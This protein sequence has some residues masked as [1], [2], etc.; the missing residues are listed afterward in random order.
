MRQIL[1]IGAE[2][3]SGPFF[4]PDEATI[5]VHYLHQ[6]GASEGSSAPEAI[7]GDIEHY[8]SRGSG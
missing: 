2:I 3:F 4:G 1:G 7:F 6:R 5:S 8:V